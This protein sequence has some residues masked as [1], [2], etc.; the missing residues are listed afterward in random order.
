MK[1]L[2]YCWEFPP[3]GTGVAGYIQAMTRSLC[4]AGHEILIV[5]G[6]SPGM[7]ESTQTVN[8][9]VLRL[10]ERHEIGSM[11][12]ARKVLQLAREAGVD[13]IEGADHLGEAAVFA[14]MQGCPPLVIKAHSCNAMRVLRR[15]ERLYAWQAPLM[16]AA[17]LRQWRRYLAEYRSFKVADLLLV[18]SRRMHD[19]IVRQGLARAETMRVV[20]NPV[21]PC[22][23]RSQEGQTPTILY[24]GRISLGKGVAF[25]PA[26]MRRVLKR[27]P[28]AVLE[29]AGGDSYARGL[30]ALKAWLMVEMGD[31]M[32]SVRFLGS[33]PAGKLDA[34]Y[35]RA[36]VLAVPSRWDSFSNVTLE[37]MARGVPVVASPH[38]GMPELLRGTGSPIADPATPAFA[39]AIS[40]L[41]NDARRRRVLGSGL[42]QRAVAAYYPDVVVREYLETVC[43]ALEL[44][45]DT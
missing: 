22:E 5:T 29:L 2:F 1:I 23:I 19:E 37:A 38:G 14:G 40:D 44:N 20:P 13:W 26:M 43:D 17:L 30:G 41:L 42:H 32:K 7:P 12:V 25:L 27:H 9:R 15:S 11:V 3:N 8:G 10:Y 45:A 34:A 36:W 18:P 4:S 35:Q 16:W 33:L 24:V 39:D 6:K 21:V 28:D 31:M